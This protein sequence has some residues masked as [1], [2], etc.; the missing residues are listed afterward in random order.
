MAVLSLVSSGMYLFIAAFRVY[1]NHSVS[2]IFK[3]YI[4]ARLGTTTE[5][6]ELISLEHN[7]AYAVTIIESLYG[8]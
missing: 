1:P 2:F 4:E 6:S 8:L 3:T 5:I 7:I